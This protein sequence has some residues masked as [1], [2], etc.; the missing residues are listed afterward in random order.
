MCPCH[1][2]GIIDVHVVSG[3]E[4]VLAINVES[5][6]SMLSVAWNVSLPSRWNHWCPCCQWHGMCPCHQCGIIDV[7]VVSGMECV[8]AINVESLMSMLSVMECDLAIN[9]E[10]LT[11]MLSLSWNVAIK[12]E[13]LTSML[14]VA[15]NVSLPS[16]WNHWCPCCQWHGIWPCHQCGIIDVHVVMLESSSGIMECCQWHGMC[17]CHQHWY[18]WCPCCQ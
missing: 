3:M 2:G 14:S 4:C 6:T 13:S 15:W 12:V 1:Q 5:L 8:L 7:L 9:V 17:P 18:H 10:S 11:S 16:M